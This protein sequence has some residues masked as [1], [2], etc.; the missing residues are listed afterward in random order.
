MARVGDGIGRGES[1][2]LVVTSS[3]FRLRERSC[4]KVKVWSDKGDSMS[5][6]DFHRCVQAFTLFGHAH[7][8][9]HVHKHRIYN[10]CLI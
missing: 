3:R 5:F 7:I 9:I 10:A 2:G 6:S 1:P 8:G 4:L